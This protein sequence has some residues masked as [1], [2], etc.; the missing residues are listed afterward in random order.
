M[1]KILKAQW[2]VNSDL[3][4]EFYKEFNKD[5]VYPWS[6]RWEYPFVLQNLDVKDGQKILDVGVSTPEFRG[7][8]T[9]KYD[10]ELDG[11][12]CLQISFQFFDA[13]L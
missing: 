4:L 12:C 9:D 13:L 10:I 6:R 8:L 5:K 7:M 1:M 11:G 3:Q 2:A